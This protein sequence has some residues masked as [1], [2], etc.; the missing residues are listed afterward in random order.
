[1]RSIKRLCKNV[2]LVILGLSMAL[3]ISEGALRIYNPFDFRV[4][5]DSI[6]LPANETYVLE[7][8]TMEKLDKRIVHKKN[9]LGFRGKEPPQN[10]EDYL[11]IIA[12]GGS[13][14]ECSLLSDGKTWPDFLGNM[15]E[16]EVDKVWVNN[17]G[18]D[19]HSTFGHYVL[20]R[21]YIVKIKPDIV[22]FL[23]GVNDI[24]SEVPSAHDRRN[25]KYGAL[26]FTSYECF[27]VSLASYSEVANMALNMARSLRAH[28]RGLPHSQVD[29]SNFE[30]ITLTNEY[31]DRV[32]EEHDERYLP[33][34]R[35]R[36]MDIM[37]ISRENGI[38]PIFITQPALFGKGID[39]ITKVNL[40]TIKL[41][42]NQNG[43]LMWRLRELYNDVVRELCGQ[44][45]ILVIDLATDMPKN[46]TYYY[47]FGHFTNEGA[48]K[49]AEIIFNALYPYVLER[50]LR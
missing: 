19:G 22:L 32:L 10:F 26:C 34:Y 50:G 33:L 29:L 15:L 16:Q 49:A 35:D 17:A 8:N 5:A 23:V 13:T 45:G 4:K 38:E 3:L 46:S 11:T 30:A 21:D 41:G 7:N 27:S 44:E 9:S 24:G 18:L 25:V 14:T 12:V 39:N 28:I 48:H 40:E 31:M 2:V 20:M 1:M 47:D 36:L 43:L 37:R 6:V 42:A